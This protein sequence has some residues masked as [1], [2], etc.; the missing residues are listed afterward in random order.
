GAGAG[1][2]DIAGAGGGD[3]SVA[4]TD[5]GAVDV[6]VAPGGAGDD[7]IGIHRGNR[8]AKRISRYTRQIIG[9]AVAARAGDGDVA[10]RP[11][12]AGKNTICLYTPSTA[13]TGNGDGAAGSV[14]LST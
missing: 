9:A 13:G 2:G 10:H 12:T 11:A 8:Y 5:P 3:A 4:C 1:D 7:D 6:A 14:H